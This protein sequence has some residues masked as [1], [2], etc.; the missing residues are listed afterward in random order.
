MNPLFGMKIIVEPLRPRYTLPDDVPTGGGTREEFA[1]WSKRVC[2]YAS[3]ILKDGQIVTTPFG[4]HCNAATF[5]QI[6]AAS[7][8]QEGRPA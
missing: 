7:K 1:D 5:E 8:L 3:P 6:K 2:G 4:I